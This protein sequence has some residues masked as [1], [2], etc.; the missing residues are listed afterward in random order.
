[1]IT[2]SRKS[3]SIGMLYGALIGALFLFGAV[4]LLLGNSAQA[5][6]DYPYSDDCVHSGCVDP[7]R[8]YKRQC[9]SFVAWRLN[10]ANGLVFNNDY[11]RDGSLD[12][13]DASNWKAA[14]QH[15]GIRV[16]NTP[17]VGAVAWQKGGNH[18]AWV[19]EVHDTTVTIEEYNYGYNYSY[20]RRTKPKTM[21]EYIHFKDLSSSNAFTAGIYTQA[22]GSYEFH[23]N[24]QN[25]GNAADRIF[26]YG[27][28]SGHHTVVMGDW[29][30]NGTTTAGVVSTTSDGKL[31]WWLRNKHSGGNADVTF[32]YGSAGDI[33]VVGD[34]DGNGTVTIGVVKKSGSSWRWYLR[35][36]NSAG[37]THHKFNYGSTNSTPITGDWNGNGTWSQG[38]VYP[39]SDDRLRWLLR[40]S[41]NGGGYQIEVIYGRR[42]MTPITG[43]WDGNGTFTPGAVQKTSTNLKWHLRNSNTSGVADHAFTYGSRSHRPIVGDWDGVN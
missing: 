34:W 7:W 28:T 1:M 2:I 15:F 41:L 23:L 11:D 18:V 30:G 14:A 38:V 17:A 3:T 19:S 8:F 26:R 10:A 12:F 16:D 43:D 42:G 32:T 5:A 27:N 31:K 40:N 13:R 37:A 6:D 33:P 24:N 21:F 35:N 20:N 22:G 29:N 39:R 25:A 4:S 36:S 9:T